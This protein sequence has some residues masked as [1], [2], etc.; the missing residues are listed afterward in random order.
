M[1]SVSKIKKTMVLRNQK[2][3]AL[4]LVAILLFVFIG[5]AALAI[6]FSHLYVVRNELQNAADAGALAGARFLYTEDGSAINYA[7]NTIERQS[8]R[9]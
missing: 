4:P 6:D 3:I 2:G 9:L 8:D 1:K 7:G 5:I